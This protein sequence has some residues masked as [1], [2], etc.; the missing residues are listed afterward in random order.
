MSLSWESSLSLPKITLSLLP[1]WAFY[2]K[3]EEK[4]VWAYFEPFGKV[5]RPASSL[6]L[7][8]CKPKIRPGPSSPSPGSFP[9]C[10]VESKKNGGSVWLR[11]AFLLISGF[12][13]RD[14]DQGPTLSRRIERKRKKWG[15]TLERRNIGSLKLLKGGRPGVDAI[16]RILT[17]GVTFELLNW[18]RSDFKMS[19]GRRNESTNLIL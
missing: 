8:Y 9:L 4:S 7:I 3:N 1:A 18:V 11:W 2:K 15:K 14:I 5:T 12:R 17:V 6:G 13:N 19:L 16:K 10:N